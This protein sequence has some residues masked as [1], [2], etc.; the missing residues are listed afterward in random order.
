MGHRQLGGS[1]FIG[2]DFVGQL[3]L[4]ALP[5]VIGQDGHV[6]TGD[7]GE[8]GAKGVEAAFAVFAHVA[9]RDGPGDVLRRD[10]C[11][12]VGGGHLGDIGGGPVGKVDLVVE[13]GDSGALDPGG[14]VG[15]S[16]D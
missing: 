4:Q 13:P 16:V 14:A 5:V 2:P 3:W 15:K 9:V 6:G 12:D 10:P 1:Y 11:G 8:V 7:A